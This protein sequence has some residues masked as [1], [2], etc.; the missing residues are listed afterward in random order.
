M[1]YVCCELRAMLIYTSFHPSLVHDVHDVVVELSPVRHDLELVERSN[2]SR[3]RI[4]G[5]ARLWTEMAGASTIGLLIKPRLAFGCQ[6]GARE[7]RL[8][9]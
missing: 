7:L 6:L 4:C 9:V 5:Q 3:D 1:V 8:R 2:K